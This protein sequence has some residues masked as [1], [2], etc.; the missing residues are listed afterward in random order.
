MENFYFALGYTFIV[1]VTAFF[2]FNY[3]KKQ[4]IEEACMVFKDK[5]P[6][7]FTRMRA[8][9]RQEIGVEIE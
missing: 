3:G 7:A 2:Y 1:M 9:L 8:R 5:E 6:E 4:G